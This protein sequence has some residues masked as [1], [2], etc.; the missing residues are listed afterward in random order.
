MASAERP[1]AGYT[2]EDKDQAMADYRAAADAERE[3]TARLK[4]LR[5]E[6]EAAAKR[7]AAR[8]ARAEKRKSSASAAKKRVRSK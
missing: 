6:K 1:Q 3:K 5:L 2:Q 4:A 8:K 7:S